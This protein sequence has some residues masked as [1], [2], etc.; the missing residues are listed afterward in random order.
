MSGGRRAASRPRGARAPEGG[1]AGRRAV[2]IG[3]GAAVFT[4]PGTRPGP[5]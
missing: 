2:R 4:P 5:R 1:G 3:K